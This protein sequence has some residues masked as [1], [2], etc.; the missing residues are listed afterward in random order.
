VDK[1]LT[2][3]QIFSNKISLTKDDDVHVGIDVHKRSYSVAI[4]INDASVVDFAM[5]AEANETRTTSDESQATSYV[6]AGRLS[7]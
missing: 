1:R 2:R 3:K 5:P 4:W 6:A 7:C